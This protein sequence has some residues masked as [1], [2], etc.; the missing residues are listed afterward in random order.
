MHPKGHFTNIPQEEDTNIS[1]SHM[2]KLALEEVK[3]PKSQVRIV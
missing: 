1:M 3:L 2:R